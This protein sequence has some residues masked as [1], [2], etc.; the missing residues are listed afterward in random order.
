MFARLSGWRA[1]T[2]SA[3]RHR[4]YRRYWF[5]QLLSLVGSWMQATAQQYLVLELTG[6]SSTALGYVTVAQFLPS[7]LLSLF[8]GA[9]VDRVPRRRVLLATQVTLLLT[10][11]TLAVTTHLGV[12]SL[13]LVMAIAFVAGIA[14]AFDMPARQSMV[15]DFVPRGDVPNAV[16]LNSLSF[17][18]S[19]TVGQ[20]LFGV[21]AAAVTLPAVQQAL[22]G[23]VPIRPEEQNFLEAGLQ[24]SIGR[25]ASL[26][27]AYYHKNSR[28][29]QDNDNFLDTGIIFPISLARIRVNGVEGRLVGPVSRGF[30]YTLSVTHSRAVATPPFTGG[31]FLG[32]DAIDSFT[33][34]AFIIDHDQP[35]S[36][37]GVVSWNHPKGWYAT[38]SN[39]YD[40]GLV[41]NPSDPA[42]VAADPDFFDLL[43]YVKLDQ[44][45]ARVRPRNIVDLVIGFERT[46]NQK[47]RYDI[48]LQFTNL[49]D[50]TA[51]YN[52]QSIFVGTRV[53]QPFT[54]GIR[55]RWYF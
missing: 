43:P 2:F 21:V 48:G 15:V 18:V 19:R 28:N 40:Y 38:V 3:L 44:R 33:Q 23:W 55:L 1:R 36:V 53:V 45:P 25:K 7:L 17:N 22:G 5:S 10:A 54:A 16:A 34:G 8:A 26:N 41:A 4:H 6:G 27:V 14:N 42:E 52:F 39:R 13:P 29:L 20:A 37:H 11:A 46:R 51:L 24:Q 9:V 49:T 47:K 50:R 35:L 31:L 12:V 30:S 32:N